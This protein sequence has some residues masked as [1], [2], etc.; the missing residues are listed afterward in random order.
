MQVPTGIANQSYQKTCIM[1]RRGR[2]SP[3]STPI[4]GPIVRPRVRLDR[5]PARQR[6]QVRTVQPPGQGVTTG[7]MATLAAEIP[8]QY[9]TSVPVAEL[10]SRWLEPDPIYR[11]FYNPVARLA[12]LSRSY[13]TQWN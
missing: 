3:R 10:N 2:E 1:S 12:T 4:A 13:R 6:P 11:L 8:D 7:G 5:L 9:A